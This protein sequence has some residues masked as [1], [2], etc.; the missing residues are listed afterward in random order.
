[1]RGIDY[2]TLI[3]FQLA[4]KIRNN[5]ISL[6]SGHKFIY[7]ALEKNSGV[8]LQKY[9]EE[10]KKSTSEVELRKR[11]RKVKFV[12][13]NNTHI[14]NLFIGTLN[15]MF[16][17]FEE[18]EID[19]CIISEDCNLGTIKANKITIKDS[20][21]ENINSINLS[22]SNLWLLR[23][24]INKLGNSHINSREINFDECN[25]DYYNLFFKSNFPKLETLFI[26]TN[27]EYD[28]YTNKGENL[29]N[30]FTYLPFSCPNLKK[31]RVEAKVD[32]LDFLVRLT[33]LEKVSILST[34]EEL[35]GES[36][37]INDL[38]KLKKMEEKNHI[39]VEIQKIM[40]GVN[41][42]L[43][44]TSYITRSEMD[45]IIKLN[46]F[47]RKLSYTEQEKEALMKDFNFNSSYLSYVYN[48]EIQEL[49]GYYENYYDELVYEENDPTCII[50]TTPYKLV[51]KYGC[52]YY[53]RDKDII[54]KPQKAIF[55][56]DGIPIVLR[57]VTKPILTIEDA[58]DVI[59]DRKREPERY[60]PTL[61]YIEKISEYAKEMKNTISVNKFISEV[62]EFGVI[63]LD[64]IYKDV[65][66]RLIGDKSIIYKLLKY[67][68]MWEYMFH[69]RRVRKRC[70]HLFSKMLSDKINLFT[71]EEMIVIMSM[72]PFK[73]D[74]EKHLWN[75]CC[76]GELINEEI[77]NS[78]DKKCDYKYIDLLNSINNLDKIDRTL[79]YEDNSEILTEDDLKKI[80]KLEV[81][82][83]N[84][85]RRTN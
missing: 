77:I 55:Y 66:N 40:Y 1:M 33:K 8:C 3:K 73:D 68:K 10:L 21:I 31:L 72:F 56:I 32:D 2:T 43:E 71:K 80:R 36:L 69:I 82:N 13:I 15:L 28:G 30:S 19:S 20:I 70:L 39:N 23:C 38:D 79:L 46:R 34:H 61:E 49:T 74:F 37:E 83:V 58:K 59:K 48:N 60:D 41:N 78:I 18:L 17:N 11:L 16:P 35:L 53:D 29:K 4:S 14:N 5:T 65:L 51:Y 81:K 42:K 84:K 7:T 47:F 9:L 75:Y 6:G 44:E 24:N 25:I 12:S 50:D 54:V 67:D 27:F 45:R 64:L 26:K 22:Q 52:I 57:K 76:N 63:D 85:R 62:R